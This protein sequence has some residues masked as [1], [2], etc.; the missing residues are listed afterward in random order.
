MPYSFCAKNGSILGDLRLP[1]LLNWIISSSG[2]ITR[3]GIVGDR[4][5]GTVCRSHLQGSRF[6]R[7]WDID[8][9]G[10]SVSNHLTPRNNPEDGG[11]IMLLRNVHTHLVLQNKTLI[12]FTAFQTQNLTYFNH[13]TA[14]MRV[15]VTLKPPTIA[16]S[17]HSGS[18][19]FERNTGAYCLVLVPVLHWTV[20]FPWQRNMEC[21]SYRQMCTMQLQGQR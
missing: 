6:S 12:P 5:F 2:F 15:R 20:R 1:P 14:I 13:F 8:K 4:R 10:L 3:R 11:G 19:L 21:C 16:D 18:V 17:A 9:T 7:R